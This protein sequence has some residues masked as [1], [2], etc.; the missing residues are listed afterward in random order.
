MARQQIDL[1]QVVRRDLET[2]P[3]PCS[4]SA[5]GGWLKRASRRICWRAAERRWVGVAG[6][7][8]PGPD[9][10]PARS[11]QPLRPRR[12]DGKHGGAPRR[13][14]PLALA[15]HEPGDL[16]HGERPGG[17]E[18]AA[19]GTHRQ[20]AANGTQLRLVVRSI[21]VRRALTLVQ[22]DH[23]LPIHPS[24]SQALAASSQPR[25]E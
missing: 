6:P 12:T 17:I 21:A 23:L 13:R 18:V 20:A 14:L 22:M 11:P 10:R 15:A 9:G 8:R 16:G 1:H 5:R 25:R 7:G 4:I 24:L 19:A 3:S 2:P